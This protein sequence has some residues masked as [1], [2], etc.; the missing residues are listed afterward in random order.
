MTEEVSKDFL[1]VLLR[2]AGC[3]ED[4]LRTQVLNPVLEMQLTD[5][6]SSGLRRASG[7][8]N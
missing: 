7:N 8:F 4:R 2:L 3:S 5:T 6:S 1:L